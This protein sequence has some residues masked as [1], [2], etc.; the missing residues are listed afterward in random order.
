[1]GGSGEIAIN[2]EM[3]SNRAYLSDWTKGGSQVRVEPIGTDPDEKEDGGSGGSAN[4]STTITMTNPKS[5]RTKLTNH[6]G[7]NCNGPRDVC[8]DSLPN[9]DCTVKEHSKYIF[10][11]LSVSRPLS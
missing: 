3:T 8:C 9:M 1:M 5:Q 4:S 11:T 2:G 7:A 6:N 10:F